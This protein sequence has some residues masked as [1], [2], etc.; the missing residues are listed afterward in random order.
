M[1]DVELK[2]L[3]GDDLL[4]LQSDGKR[5]EL[6]EGMLIDMSPT[7]LEHSRVESRVA[8]LLGL[9]LMEN[10]LGQVFTGE[11]GFYTRG[12]K[13]T[14]RGADV[15]Y[16]SYERM[17]REV[18]EPGYSHIAPDLVVEVI[19]PY[20]RTGDI[21]AKTQEWLAFGVREVW[22]VY[23][24]ARS[25]HIYG[26]A[27]RPAILFAGQTLDGGAVLPGFSAEIAQFFE[28]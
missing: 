6:I 8:F 17:P 20:D 18:V 26:R 23:P 5:Y 24:G 25:I 15:A 13:H 12:T 3:T 21:E 4:E 16:I 1:S 27:E 28:G 11:A 2:R 14:T 9:F 7:G 19:S 10:K 22:N